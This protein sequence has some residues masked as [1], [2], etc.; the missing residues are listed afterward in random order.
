MCFEGIFK[1]SLIT[2][3]IIKGAELV[4][5]HFKLHICLSPTLDHKNKQKLRFMQ[6]CVALAWSYLKLKIIGKTLQ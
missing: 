3:S 2:T 6:L 1:C 4:F 5:V